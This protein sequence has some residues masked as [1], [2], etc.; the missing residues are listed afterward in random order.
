MTERRILEWEREFITRAILHK[1][2]KFVRLSKKYRDDSERLYALLR[3][4]NER[5]KAL[6]K[7][8]EEDEQA[9]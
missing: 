6:E 8:A 2:Q 5:I 3:E 7:G 9:E 1:G 4:V